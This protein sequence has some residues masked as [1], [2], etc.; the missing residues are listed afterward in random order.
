[1]YDCGRIVL[2]CSI[3]VSNHILFKDTST[4]E[5]AALSV[6]GCYDSGSV[7]VS[8]PL[9]V[10]PLVS[11]FMG[12]FVRWSVGLSVHWSVGPLVRWSVCP[13]VCRVFGLLVGWSVGLSVLWSVGP[14]GLLSVCPLACG[15]C[16]ILALFRSAEHTSELYCRPPTRGRRL[17]LDIILSDTLVD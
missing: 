3:T 9:S 16:L 5:I 1:M 17:M 13:L 4:S 8:V 14:V 10:G 7:M 11:R 6:L 2:V 12:P 15:V